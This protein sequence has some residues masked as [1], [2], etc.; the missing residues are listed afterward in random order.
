MNVS[1]VNVED[2]VSKHRRT[3]KAYRNAYWRRGVKEGVKYEEWKFAENAEY[4]SPY[5]TGNRV[6]ELGGMVVDVATY[7]TMEAKPVKFPDWGPVD[8]KCWPPDN[9]FVMRTLFRGHHVNSGE[10]TSF[11]SVGFVETNEEFEVTSWQ[12]FVNGDEFSPFLEAAI[13]VRGP[14]IKGHEEYFEAV[15]RH[16]QKYGLTT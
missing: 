7:A 2:R 4:W 10:E 3:A 6:I 16:L 13:G 8:F 5:F 15:S 1:K 9:G 14:F 12:T 11:Y